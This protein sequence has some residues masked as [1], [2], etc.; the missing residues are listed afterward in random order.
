MRHAHL[1]GPWR[2]VE[3]TLTLR[4]CK[5]L[6]SFRIDGRPWFGDVY[7]SGW[8]EMFDWWMSDVHLKDFVRRRDAG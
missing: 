8:E 5:G 2:G 4:R 7:F 3:W 1:P 6:G